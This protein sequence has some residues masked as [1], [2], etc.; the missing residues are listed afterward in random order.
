MNSKA[1]P[2]MDHSCQSF[3]T[4]FGDN[5]LILSVGG[6]EHAILNRSEKFDVRKQSWT[7]TDDLPLNLRSSAL[8][9]MGKIPYLIGKH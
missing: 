2:K 9:E 6:G 5:R 8:I 7:L 4:G 3:T 1:G